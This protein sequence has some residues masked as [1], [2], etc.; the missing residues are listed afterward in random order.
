MDMVSTVIPTNLK[1]LGKK[2]EVVSL[3]TY[4]FQFIFLIAFIFSMFLTPLFGRLAKRFKVVD[5]PGHRK[6]HKEPVSY[7]GGVAL[8]LS[9]TLAFVLAFFLFDGL[10]GSFTDRGFVKVL[11]ILGASLGVAAIGILD[12][13]VNLSARYK[14]M[15]QAVFALGFTFFGFQFQVLHLPGFPAVNLGLL[16]V[17]VTVFWILAV[18]NAFN[19]VDGV[20]GLAA[21]V[22][23]GSLLLLAAAAALVENGVE[24]LLALAALGAVFGFLPYNWKPAKI[25]LG[26]AGSGGLGMFLACSLVALGQHFG[27]K[28]SPNPLLAQPYIYQI[29]IVTLLVSYP[30]LEITLSTTRRFLRGR[31]IWRADKGHIHHRLQNVGWKSQGICV[32]ALIMTLLPGAA[33]LTTLA[34]YHGWAAILLV[35]FG[36]FIGLGLSTLGFLDFITPKV[37]ARLK[38][39]YQIAHHFISMQKIKL[40]LASNREEVLTLIDQTCQELGVKGYRL[41]IRSDRDLKGGLDYIHNFDPTRLSALR[42]EDHGPVDQVRLPGGRGGAEWMFENQVVEEELDVEYRVL[43]SEF[44]SLGLEKAENLGR[45][46][47][48]LEMPSVIALHQRRV[49]SHHLRKKP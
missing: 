43:L 27:E 46:L 13:V 2:V 10:T 39:H 33:A 11:F 16:S 19:M 41:I 14:L 3:K 30:I 7:F 35:I 20:D 40:S 26:D 29:L 28:H 6:T 4:Q 47:V 15:G 8:M 32:A 22:A 37:L 42:I 18:V 44:M 31:P 5:H 24:L 34:K 36:S 49:S 1:R 38:P 21:T 48:T 45:D 12:D 17:P 23:A 25:Y 9:L